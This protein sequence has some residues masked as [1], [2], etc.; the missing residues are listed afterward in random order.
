MFGGNAIGISIFN[1]QYDD[2]IGSAI[3]FKLIKLC[4]SIINS[5]VVND[6]RAICLLRKY[7]VET[8]SLKQ[9][10]SGSGNEIMERYQQKLDKLEKYSM[11]QD[12]NALKQI[13][14]RASITS[15]MQELRDKY[16]IF[17]KEKVKLQK[18]LYAAEEDKINLSKAFIELEIENANLKEMLQNNQVEK[19]NSNLDDEGKDLEVRMKLEKA[20]NLI[21]DLQG[22]LD[23]VL[24]EK[25]ELELEFIAL[26]K[27][28]LNKANEL[29]EQNKKNEKLALELVDLLNENKALC[30]SN[31]IIPKT[32]N[33]VR[34]QRNEQ[35]KEDKLKN[36]I[37]MLNAE[38]EKTKAEKLK[39]EIAAERAKVEYEEKAVKLEKKFI[40]MPGVV[41]KSEP[42][43]SAL[44][45]LEKEDWEKE[46]LT[47]QRRCRELKRKLEAANHDHE[48][49]K[50][51]IKHLQKEREKLIAEFEELQV[52]YRK[53]LSSVMGE[54]AAESLVAS[55]KSHEQNLKN[56]I[57]DLNKRIDLL[58]NKCK[59]LRIYG[60]EL[61][62]LAEDLLPEDQPKPELLSKPEPSI[63][64]EEKDVRIRKLLG[65]DPEIEQLKEENMR[66]KGEIKELIKVK[67]IEGS[68]IQIKI[69]EELKAL[70]GDHRSLSR[71]G[72]ANPD[73]EE[74]RKERNHLLEEN[75]KLKK[76]V[77]S[78]TYID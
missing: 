27:N 3:T 29:E 17:V 40:A 66:L 46:K 76:I 38:L 12:L 35:E 55:Y 42:E 24:E 14:E 28:F 41:T 13:D 57:E 18:Q 59:D 60:R 56:N 10:L 78:L 7:R 21:T 37:T 2:P 9:I 19:Q 4:Q 33:S 49:S 43:A 70:K 47:Y 8:N 64:K 30:N 58:Q 31:S 74:L 52:A 34:S 5:P 61:N 67:P 68:E 63:L 50:E 22:V 75:L 32:S 51:E 6:N 26:R 15:Q 48:E 62:A 11:D 25:K 71:P 65:S 72:T 53:N 54:K 16:T 20:Q 23:K 77:C 73:I 44:K 36:E 1:L 45:K 69:L 39:A